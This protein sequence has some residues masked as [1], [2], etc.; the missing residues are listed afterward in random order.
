MIK[1]AVSDLLVRS[2]AFALF[3]YLNRSK[4]PILMY[5]RF[6]EKE[7][8]GKTSLAALCSHLAYLTKH[9]KVLSLTEAVSF[10]AN[11]R[12]LPERAAVITIDD[13]YAD[14]FNIALPVF[15]K[16]G[17]AATLYVVTDFVDG[18]LWIW[19]DKAR[20]LLKHTALERINFMIGDK[21][22]DIELKGIESRHIAAGKLNSE[23]KKLS[24]EEKD[25]VL[26]ELADHV[27]VEM[28]EL[29]PQEFSAIS[30]QQ[31]HELETSGVEIGSHTVTHPILTNIG[32]EN[33]RQ[34]LHGSRA[35]IQEKLQKENV[36]FCY[37]NGNVS[38]RERD[39]AERSGY[40]SAVTTEIRL[41]E[42]DSDKFLLPRIDAEPQLSR[43]IKATSGFDAY[44]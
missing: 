6:S 34:E 23:L 21:E 19:T 35:V 9:Y 40:A 28:P 2:N 37:P 27:S 10:I 4:M 5:H 12:T 26:S 25:A 39:V 1:A 17:V 36:H 14:C 30:W 15:K 16:Y 3:R 29:P 11:E 42:K 18:R 20:Y 8:I 43:F 13:G 38:R 44:R 31:A 22:F 33:L 24:D 7:E 41:C 32:D